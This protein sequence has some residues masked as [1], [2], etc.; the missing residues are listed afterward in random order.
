MGVAIIF[1]HVH[2]FYSPMW[3]NL[4]KCIWFYSNMD[5]SN[6]TR[7]LSIFNS[8]LIRLFIPIYM[9]YRRRYDSFLALAV[10]DNF[11]C[12]YAKNSHP[13]KQRGSWISSN[14]P[15]QQLPLLL[16]T[17]LSKIIVSVA[18]SVATTVFSRREPCLMPPCK[19]CLNHGVHPHEQATLLWAMSIA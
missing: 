16:Y 11:L 18:S 8:S 19:R 13:L 4:F 2:C 17:P 12:F 7:W 6:H 5:C 9:S 15:P 10:P 3:L 14:M 1:L